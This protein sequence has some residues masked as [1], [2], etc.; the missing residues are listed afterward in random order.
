LE[1]R[2]IESCQGMGCYFKSP[3][4][5]PNPYFVIFYTIL[6]LQKRVALKFEVLVQLKEIIPK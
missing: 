3:N 5:W 2:E 6:F 1:G 4:I